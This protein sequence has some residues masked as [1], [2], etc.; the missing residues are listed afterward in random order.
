[1]VSKT[2]DFTVHN[3]F[4]SSFIETVDNKER[5]KKRANVIIPKNIA[6]NP[7]NVLAPEFYI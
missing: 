1:M 4:V 6:K 2:S 3:Q 7:L 5:I